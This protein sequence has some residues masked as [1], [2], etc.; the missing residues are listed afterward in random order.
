W[1]VYNYCDPALDAAEGRALTDYGRTARKADYH[2]VQAV[3]ADDLPILVLWFQ[4]RQ[5]VV[6]VDLKNYKPSQAV[7]PF[8]NSWQWEI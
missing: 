1:N 4:Q 2:R 8:W 6:N 5:D 7:S 3:L